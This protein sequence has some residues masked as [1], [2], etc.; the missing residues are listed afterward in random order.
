MFCI[1]NKHRSLSQ[2]AFEISKVHFSQTEDIVVLAVPLM[3]F[4]LSSNPYMLS[5]VHLAFCADAF[6]TLHPVVIHC[7]RNF[8]HSTWRLTACI[9]FVHSTVLFTCCVGSMQ[10]LQMWKTLSH[11]KNLVRFYG[12]CEQDGKVSLVLEYMEVMLKK[13]SSTIL[14][15]TSYCT[16]TATHAKQ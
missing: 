9:P 14:C 11:H 4:H 6:V 7:M 1:C 13:Q 2:F 10:E 8:A 5:D 15:S 3:T 16:C 12:S